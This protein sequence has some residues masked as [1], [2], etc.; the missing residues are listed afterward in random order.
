MTH[1]DHVA[2][3]EIRNRLQE[4]RAQRDEARDG[5]NW[6]QFRELQA[7]IDSVEGTRIEIMRR[8]P[9]EDTPKL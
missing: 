6:S 7:E 3:I 9:P 2:L 8:T 1:D 5:S 4:V